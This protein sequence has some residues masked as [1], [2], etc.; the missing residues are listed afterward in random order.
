M[1]SVS[2]K[3]FTTV[4]DHQTSVEIHVL[5]GES[6]KAGENIS[7][8]RFLLSGIRDGRR[9]DPRIEVRFALDMDGIVTVRAHDVET[10][11]EQRITVT[12]AYGT[13]KKEGSP[14]TERL[15]LKVNS[16]LD[17]VVKTADIYNEYIERA[18]RRE[19][20]EVVKSSKAAVLQADVKGMKRNQTALEI[21]IG[22]LNECV[23][24]RGVTV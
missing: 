4:A 17:R 7:L 23:P 12:P 14:E 6:L 20:D 9:G 13:D 10:L 16:L 1:V 19:I 8:G 3:I 5:Q 18:F 24:Q 22:E 15:K 21:I 2:K 11:A